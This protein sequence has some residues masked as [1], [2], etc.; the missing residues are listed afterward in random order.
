MIRILIKKR[1]YIVYC[2][3]DLFLS[4]YF[5]FSEGKVL[6]RKLHLVFFIIKDNI[7]YIQDKIRIIPLSLYV[8]R[9]VFLIFALIIKF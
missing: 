3:C 2:Q 5:F 9:I 6:I 1:F 4:L 8:F 7:F